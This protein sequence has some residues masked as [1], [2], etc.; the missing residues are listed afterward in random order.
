MAPNTR[1]PRWKQALPWVLV[2]ALAA[3]A[4][5]P[6]LTRRAQPEPL[7]QFEI[8][9]PAGRQI[10]EFRISHDGSA[11]VF[12]ANNRQGARS[13]WLRHLDSTALEELP[14]TEGATFPF[15]SPDGE[16]IAFFAAGKLRRLDLASGTV[17][18]IAAAANGRGGDWHES[19]TVLFT[20]EGSDVLYSVPA[21]G[22]TPTAV[23]TVSGTQTTHRFPHFLAGSDRFVFSA[24]GANSVETSRFLGSLENDQLV[25]LP[26]GMSEAYAPPGFLLYIVEGTLVAQD[27][28]EA[29]GHLEGERFPL[30]SG[31]ND[32]FPRTGS[33][34]FSVSD[35]GVLAFL[36][37]PDVDSNFRLMN[38]DGKVLG[39]VGPEAIYTMPRVSKDG[40]RIAFIRDDAT[41]LLDF[42]RGTSTRVTGA[43]VG[44]AN[45]S[46][47][48]FGDDTAVLTTSVAGIVLN[49]LATGRGELIFSSSDSEQARSLVA[50]RDPRISPDGSYLAFSAWDPITDYDLWVLRLADE[51]EPERLGATPRVQQAPSISPNGRWIAYESDESGR[52]EIY[53]R[54]ATPGDTKWLISTGG[55]TAPLWSEDGTELFYISSEDEM[56]AVSIGGSA[57]RLDAGLPRVLFKAPLAPPLN[58][59]MNVVVEPRLAGL[60]DGNFLFQVPVEDLPPRTITVVLNWER[61]LHR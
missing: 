30:A 38:R 61:L 23:T 31:I 15:W 47:A 58:R 14:E 37:A 13:L 41:W 46:P 12:A 9:A 21:S 22:G 39:T 19:G 29:S 16:A 25:Q 6:L 57:S 42:V 49:E 60:V 45:S 44:P 53:V 18:T 40:D 54:P 17:Q 26:D 10:S 3:A 56:I 11:V 59:S 36:Q 33:S 35:N 48:W 43:K 34:A 55:G 5:S 20:P 51:T 4:A 7:V 32:I 52:S 27:F 24:H 50:V 1:V 2:V 28:D 8:A